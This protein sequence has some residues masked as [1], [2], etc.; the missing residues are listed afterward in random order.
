MVIDDI[1][2]K[3]REYA[4]EANIEL[5]QSAFD[6]AC[7]MHDEQFRVSGREFVEHPVGVARILAELELDVI[8]IAAALLHDVIEDT[9]TSEKE[10]KDKFGAEISRLVN[11]VTKLSMIEVKSYEERQAESLRKM[12]LAMAEDIRVILIKLADR[13][14]NMRTLKYLSREKQEKIAE[15]TL[16]IYAPLA[17]RLGISRIKWELEDLAFR[18]TAPQDYYNLVKEVVMN[19]QERESYIDEVEN[20]LQNKLEDFDVKAKIQGRPKHFYSIYQKMQKQDK[21]LNEIYDLTAVRVIVASIK[22]CYQVLGIIQ[23]PK[24]FFVNSKVETSI[25]I[26][27]NSNKKINNLVL[28]DLKEDFDED[29]NKL[30]KTW[31][32]FLEE[33]L[34]NASN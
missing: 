15:E 24:E 33:E 31:N 19:R 5:L 1:K 14:H 10:L 23:L 32:N 6:Y 28:A 25:L 27:K 17:H 7:E 29:K 12:F 26:L 2:E 13:L 21:E 30:F 18:F 3:V 34:N 20:T 22:E 4:P 16:E 9:D 11:G 8:S